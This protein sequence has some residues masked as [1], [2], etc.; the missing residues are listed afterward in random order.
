[1]LGIMQ[2]TPVRFWGQYMNEVE[3]RLQT[4]RLYSKLFISICI[5]IYSGFSILQGSDPT[6]TATFTIPSVTV[7]HSIEFRE[8]MY[9]YYNVKDK[10]SYQDDREERKKY[11]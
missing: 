1:M 5:L 6:V 3:G 10:N 4:K 9:A 11:R 8:L 2:T 7:L